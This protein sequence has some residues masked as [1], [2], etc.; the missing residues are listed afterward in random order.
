MRLYLGSALGAPRCD[1]EPIVT[2][3]YVLDGVFGIAS[4]V[5][6]FLKST[7][8]HTSTYGEAD[9]VEPEMILAR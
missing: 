2:Q 6:M 9:I 8:R 5:S 7:R 3:V 4:Q 1:D